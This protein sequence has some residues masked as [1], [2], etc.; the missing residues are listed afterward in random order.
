MSFIPK[1]SKNNDFYI[2]ASYHSVK[3]TKHINHMSSR[4]LILIKNVL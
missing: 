4:V 3:S 1:S 2:V